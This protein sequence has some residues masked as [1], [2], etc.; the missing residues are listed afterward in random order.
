M[1]F[2]CTDVDCANQRAPLV[3]SAPAGNGSGSSEESSAIAPPPNRQFDGKSVAEPSVLSTL[4]RKRGTEE[5]VI[6]PPTHPVM[7][8]QV[9]PGMLGGKYAPKVAPELPPIA[10][11]LPEPSP[12]KPPG[13]MKFRKVEPGVISARYAASSKPT[14]SGSPAADDRSSSPQIVIASEAPIPRLSSSPNSTSPPALPEPEPAKPSHDVVEPKETANASIHRPPEN[15]GRGRRTSRR[16][17]AAQHTNDVFGPSTS[18]QPLQLRR[19]RRS[20]GDGFMEMSAVALQALTTSN[21]T[22]NQAIFA[23][24]EREV[25]RKEGTRPESPAVKVRTIS[26]KQREM[27]DRQRLERAERRARRSE[28]GPG[29][30]DCEGASELGDQSLLEFE[31]ENDENDGAV[32]TKHRRGPGEVEDYETPVR[33]DRLVKRLRFGNSP[34]EEEE[35]ESKRVKWHHGLSTEI[36]LDEIHPRPNSW[37]KDF[38]IEKSCLAPTSKVSGLQELLY[39]M[40]AHLPSESSLRHTGQRD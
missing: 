10:P 31:Q 34:P 17:P 14:A 40:L 33:S 12:R 36:Y 32:W 3:K 13:P 2:D 4:K 18:T 19:S 5:T 39:Y 6:S 27:R 11:S 9:V 26:Q 1:L 23:N 28:D 21:T 16:K 38:V 29:L 20:E 7:I 8:R 37:T 22:K 25:I 30:S 24:L 15:R 35:R